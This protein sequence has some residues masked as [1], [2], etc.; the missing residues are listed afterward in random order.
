MNA[1]TDT[2]FF[3]PLVAAESESEQVTVDV[4]LG[5]MPATV[6]IDAYPCDQL[7]VDRV[8]VGGAEIDA[9]CWAE[10]QLEQWIAQ[11]R[12]QEAA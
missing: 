6:Y 4:E 2:M 9:E 7:W 1:P 10:W 12:K 3:A 5:G 8:A 11:Y